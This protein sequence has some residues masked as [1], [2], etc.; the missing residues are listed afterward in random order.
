MKCPLRFDFVL[1]GH[2]S[3][4]RYSRGT[5]PKRTDSVFISSFSRR[6]DKSTTSPAIIFRC[7]EYSRRTLSQT[8]SQTLS[9]PRR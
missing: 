2:E 6:H 7:P 3:I 5:S 4:I 8:L 9:L 1:L